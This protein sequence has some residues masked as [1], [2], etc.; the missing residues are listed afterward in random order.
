MIFDEAQTF[1]EG[2][3]NERTRRDS[4]E[5]IVT[6]IEQVRKL[7]VELLLFEVGDDY[8]GQQTANYFHRYI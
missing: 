6:M 7:E 5:R 4:E 1:P 2:Y 3:P 8:F